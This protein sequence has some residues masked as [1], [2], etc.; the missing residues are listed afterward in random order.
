MLFKYVVILR[1]LQVYLTGMVPLALK[2]QV[3]HVDYN[4]FYVPTNQ[5]YRFAQRTLWRNAI[6]AHLVVNSPELLMQ[7]LWQCVEANDAGRPPPWLTDLVP[8]PIWVRRAPFGRRNF[9]K[10]PGY[11]RASIKKF[12]PRYIQW[13]NYR[14]KS[15]WYRHTLGSKTQS[16][17]KVGLG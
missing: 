3:Q 1:M 13:R 5:L 6:F 15:G 4:N 7:R 8:R 12:S 10:S 16:R 9:T 11:S 17:P 2:I 14:P